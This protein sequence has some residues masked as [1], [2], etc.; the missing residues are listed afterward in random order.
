M[1]DESESI[2]RF[3]TNGENY[4]KMT[5]TGFDDLEGIVH[6]GG[7]Q[8]AILEERDRGGD[9]FHISIVD[10]LDDSTNIPKPAAG[11]NR[12]EIT[13]PNLHD[14]DGSF[15]LEGIAYDKATGVFYVAKERHSIQVFEVTKLEGG[16]TTLEQVQIDEVTNLEPGLRIRNIS[17]LFYTNKA[18]A[19]KTTS[20]L[21]M[22]SSD[23][24]SRKVI[25]ADK[26][27]GGEPDDPPKFDLVFNGRRP[28]EVN[29]R[30][31][32]WEG[33]A[34]TPGGFIM[35][36]VADEIN[37]DDSSRWRFRK[38]RSFPSLTPNAAPE[39]VTEC[40]DVLTAT[41]LTFEGTVARTAGVLSVPV[42]GIDEFGTDAFVWLY[43]VG[44]PNPIGGPVALGA[45]GRYS[46]LQANGLTSDAT[47]VFTIK[48]GLEGAVD[49]DRS[50][51][52]PGLTVT[53]APSV[54]SELTGNGAVDFEDLT[55]LLAN[56]N[57]NVSAGEGNLVNAGGT[58]V[59]FEDLTVLLADWTG[60][61]PI[62]ANGGAIAAV[63][64]DGEPDTVPAPA[65]R[66]AVQFDQPVNGVGVG[67]MVLGGA[68]GGAATVDAVIDYGTGTVY[69]FDISG[70]G[71]GA[72][73]V[74]LASGSTGI[75]YVANGENFAQM[76]WNFIAMPGVSFNTVTGALDI[77]GTS[78]AD[79][80]TIAASG[81]ALT[82]N[83]AKV[84]LTGS[85]ILA[86]DVK[87]IDIDGAG[88]NDTIDLSGVTTAAFTGAGLSGNITVTGGSGDDTI[89]ASQFDETFIGGTGND[90]YVF[91]AGDS[92]GTVSITESAS[93]DTDVLDF[94]G[95]TTGGITVN[96]S[97]TGNQTVDAE[98]LV[99]NLS[100]ATG[101]E[102]VIGTVNADTITGNTRNN[103]ITG[104][105]GNDTLAGGSGSDTYVFS[106]SSDLG[107]DTITEAASAD[108]DW[109][110]FT[111]FTAG[112]ISVNLATTGNQTVEPGK[113][114]LNLSSS[115]G[116]ENVY[117]S[118][119]AD[120]ITGNTRGNV[121]YGGSGDDTL[122][123]GAGADTLYGQ[124]GNDTLNGG[125]GADTLYGDAGNDTMNGGSGDD[126]MYGGADD[127]Y[128]NGGTDDDLIYGEDGDDDLWGGGGTDTLDGGNGCDS[129]EGVNEC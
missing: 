84:N 95:F 78:G 58:P 93:A 72:V 41:N 126:L 120:S 89:T 118:P 15:G 64:A 24:N 56:W 105:L 106:G 48:A 80:I 123:G 31:V 23:T 19:S 124:I 11:A 10:I 49:A 79:T 86:S 20:R 43:K 27:T 98:Q 128:M 100:S 4:Y 28:A 107:T 99:L 76:D 75:T 17:D 32:K 104:G 111:G 29:L 65:A 115:T 61:C 74:T 73:N 109:L 54:A 25:S 30:T 40:F 34:F 55:V 22:M 50:F 18:G 81:G 12:L 51:V 71:I 122:S 60:P 52:S 92:L 1:D 6:M 101:L 69:G 5:T 113:L 7:T 35:F 62:G 39:L 33:H 127:D 129:F 121:F 53:I 117:G 77:D 82:I 57:K 70:M 45:D 59:N 66:F 91:T 36:A 26:D 116:L 87:S 14:D 83:G 90:T 114:V 102:N 103:T 47:Y 108:S 16:A 88:G 42:N 3:D 2:L 46:D 94:S 37:G 63:A 67:D 85:I 112:G 13:H 125:A 110:D 119:A 9:V 21:L 44:D 96:L 97:T 68:G 38:Y 8:F